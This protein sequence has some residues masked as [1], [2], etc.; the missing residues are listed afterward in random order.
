MRRKIE[1]ALAVFSLVA[2]VVHFSGEMAYHQELGQFLPDLWVDWLAD[3]LLVTAA[4][5][6]WRGPGAVGLMCG[7]W[8]FT[9]CLSVLSFNGFFLRT[10]EGRV[11][12]GVLD[13][14]ASLA[15]AMLLSTAAFALC[16]GLAW[17]R[18]SPP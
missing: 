12:A 15:L 9:C 1:R 13:A 3:V 14:V 6:M 7:A 2:A 10:L 18:T 16:L 4:F 5:R 17:R 11:P 8:G